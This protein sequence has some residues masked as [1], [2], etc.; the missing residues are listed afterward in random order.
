MSFRDA[1]GMSGVYSA[2]VAAAGRITPHMV[3]VTVQGD[4]IRRL[5]QHGFDQW[6]RLFLPRAAGAVDFSA[7]PRRFDMAGYLRYMALP[8]ASRPPFRNY[9]VRELRSDSGELDIDFVSHGDAGIAG[10]WAAQAHP[11]EQVALID[12]GRGFDPHGDASAILLVGDESALPAIAGILR[13]SSRT[14]SGTAI[15]E[16]PDEAD[17]Q[18]IDTPPGVEV[19]WLSRRGTGRDPGET[20][21][22]EAVTLLASRGLNPEGLQVYA[23]GERR[24]AV[25]V[26]RSAVS[27]GVERSRITFT[28]YWR[29]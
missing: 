26:R 7:V 9:T 18:D 17:R 3:R 16:I 27:A 14:T 24:L 29:R 13:D 5:P 19:R 12:Q 20:A 22:A 4:N 2:T 28:G 21:L 15:I 11:G 1:R 23:A 8:G 25:G 10:P 6:F